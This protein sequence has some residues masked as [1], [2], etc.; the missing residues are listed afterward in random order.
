M[1]DRGGQLNILKRKDL[2][3]K[4]TYIKINNVSTKTAFIELNDMVKK[5]ILKRTGKGRATSYKL[6]Y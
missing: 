6:G 4:R 5:R 3:N 2:I 1:K